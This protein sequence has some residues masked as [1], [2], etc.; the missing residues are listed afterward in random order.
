M[1]R[2][3]PAWLQEREFNK[4]T[5]RETY[6]R[7]RTPTTST[8]V[9]SRKQVQL[10]YRS[11]FMKIG[12]EPLIYAVRPTEAAITAIGGAADAGLLAAMPATAGAQT[13]PLSIRGSGVTPSKA[14]WYKGASAPV[15][16]TTPWSSRWIRYYDKPATGQSHF[17]V[18]FSK[19]T[20][21][22][23]S[24]DLQGAFNALFGPTGSKK[25]L[26][27]DENGRAWLQLERAPLAYSS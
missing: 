9:N 10:F 27:G 20:G 12:A 24:A 19:A 21:A 25:A 6:Y 16:D 3:K 11:M 15:G 5:A 26:L 18:P 13:A 1:G 14:C 23:T 8:T 4:A 17:S 2:R 22:V 7:T